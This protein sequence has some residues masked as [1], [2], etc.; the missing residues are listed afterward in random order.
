MKNI[1]EIKALSKDRVEVWIYSDIGEWED[2]GDVSAKQVNTE[3]AKH[4]GKSIDLR[5]NSYGG[6]VIQA[7]AMYT[8]LKKHG[9]E[10]TAYIDGVAASAASFVVMA[11]SKI[12][13]P[14]NALM[15][16]HNPWGYAGG[17]AK[18]LRK[19]A[20]LLDKMR[21]Q[22][23]DIY[24]ARTGVEREE[25][26]AMLDSETWMTGDEAIAKGFAD[27]LSEELVDAYATASELVFAG[28]RFSRDRLNMPSRIAA[29][30]ETR[31]VKSQT[32]KEVLNMDPKTVEE[33]RAKFPELCNALVADAAAKAEASH[34]DA[35]KAAAEAAVEAERQRLQE[36][37]EIS[38]NIDPALVAKAKYETGECA[39]DLA[40]NAMKQHQAKGAVFLSARA[41]DASELGPAAVA[42]PDMSAEDN[43]ATRVM[44]AA[45]RLARLGGGEIKEAK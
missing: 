7:M 11:A 38:A 31:E 14:S 16:I 27:E 22:M 1:F 37:D 36:I 24:E 28:Q 23:L 35:I 26:A 29:K 32:P 3:L 45:Q 43:R 10:I 42:T 20:D 34:A 39:K 13:M 30:L 18:D 40:F 21:D 19:T 44:S 9:G 25:I 6:S 12:V 4:K 17:E 2:W 15:M 41:A 5:V 33:L 8:A